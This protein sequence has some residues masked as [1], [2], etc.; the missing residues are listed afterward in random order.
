MYSINDSYFTNG[1]S[2][3][4]ILSTFY[5]SLL[6]LNIS[7]CLGTYTTLGLKI[8]DDESLYS[9]KTKRN[10]SSLKTFI[11]ECYFTNNFIEDTNSVDSEAGISMY[12][13]TESEIKISKTKILSILKNNIFNRYYIQFIS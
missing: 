3:I 6:K 11:D 13:K 4:K 10:I 1:G 8:I 7:N 12:F 5:V 2:C 9:F